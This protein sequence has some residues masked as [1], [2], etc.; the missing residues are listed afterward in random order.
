ML[1]NQTVTIIVTEEIKIIINLT[2]KT[3][4]IRA[5]IHPADSNRRLLQRK[6]RSATLPEKLAKQSATQQEQFRE[7]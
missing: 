5:I 3:I 6:T 4:I 2:A 7:Q 1:P